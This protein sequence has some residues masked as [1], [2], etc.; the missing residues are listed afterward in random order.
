MAPLPKMQQSRFADLSL[1]HSAVD[2]IL[3]CKIAKDQA[4]GG[5]TAAITRPDPSHPAVQAA[6]SVTQMA[7]D[8]GQI[9]ATAQALDA[10]TIPPAPG[11]AGTGPVPGSGFVGSAAAELAI[12]DT[13]PATYCATLA[14]NYA[15]AKL[16]GRTDEEAHYEDLLC[17]KEGVCDPHWSEAAVK[18]AEFIL[19]RGKIP[20]RRWTNLNDYVI[21]GKLP[22]KARVAI[23]GDWGTG[24]PEAKN[25]LA[26]IA[27]KQPD[28]V[29]H[30]GDIYY[31]ATEFE[32][33]QLLLRHLERNAQSAGNENS[34]VHLVG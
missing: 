4:T 13:N 8:I 2:E 3:A 10:S 15:L 27:R 11:N 16:H 7:E 31:S 21:D 22:S 25:V 24:Q 23:I 26:Q 28:V 20:Y 9:H 19:A 12:C 14:R 17:K 29:I 5:G 32:V 33:K 1:F 6:A 34:D 18:Y 30:L